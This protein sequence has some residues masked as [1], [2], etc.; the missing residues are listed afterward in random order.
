[1]S[2]VESGSSAGSTRLVRLIKLIADGNQLAV[3]QLVAIVEQAPN[4]IPSLVQ[5]VRRNLKSH[6]PTKKVNSFSTDSSFIVR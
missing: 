4:Q 3:T 5:Q 6:H 2:T 1:M